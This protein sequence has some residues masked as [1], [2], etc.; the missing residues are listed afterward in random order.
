MTKLT[1]RQAIVTAAASAVVATTI[2][3]AVAHTF[4][5]P[6]GWRRGHPARTPHCAVGRPRR[7]AFRHP[8]YLPREWTTRLPRAPRPSRACMLCRWTGFGGRLDGIC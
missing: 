3:F 8:R 7:W 5:Q 2:P 4:A 1:R 6:P